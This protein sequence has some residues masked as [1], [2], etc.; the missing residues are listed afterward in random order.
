MNASIA[1][2]VKVCGL[3]RLEDA[4]LAAAHGAWALGFVFA[5]SSPRR[6]SAERVREILD[7]LPNSPL[8]VGV[9]VDQGEDEILATARTAGLRAVQLH[10]TEPAS[11]VMAL[12]ARL[13]G[14]RVF[15]ARGVATGA[16]LEGLA[17]A[18]GEDV[19]LLDARVGKRSGGLGV[20]FDWN[21]AAGLSPA[22][23]LVLAGGLRAANVGEALRVVRPFALDVSSGVECSPGVKCPDKLAD[24]F[25]A[26]KEAV[27]ES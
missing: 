16:D 19:I 2:R 11:L 1:T 3:T 26:V 6:V 22:L 20:A 25:R 24:F 14:L 12:K 4:R 21:L 9:F 15:R 13:P 23:P 8:P 7:A 10:G 5:P 17:L 27:G 18:A